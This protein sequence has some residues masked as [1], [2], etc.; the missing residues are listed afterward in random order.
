MAPEPISDEELAWREQLRQRCAEYSY[1]GIFS[2][3]DITHLL[4]QLE[5]AESQLAIFSGEATDGY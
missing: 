1:R 2:C 3:T 5:T 4:D